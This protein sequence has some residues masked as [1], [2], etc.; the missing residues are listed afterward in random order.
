MNDMTGKT[1]QTERTIDLATFRALQD[2][3]GADFVKELVDTFLEDAPNMLSD[4]RSAV[5]ARDTDRFRRAAHSLKSNSNTFGALELGAMARSLEV[6]GLERTLAATPDP[7]P[8]L[9]QEYAR[10]EQSL[11]MLRDG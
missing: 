10:V 4:L 2:A 9:L 8:R 1:Q 7:L 5:A 3:V 11:K 6:D